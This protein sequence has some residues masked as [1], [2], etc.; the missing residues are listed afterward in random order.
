MRAAPL[1]TPSIA[2]VKGL[3]AN[4]LERADKHSAICKRGFVCTPERSA[5]DHKQALTVQEALRLAGAFLAP[6]L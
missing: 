4:V 1:T 2:H 6:D 5:D 3:C